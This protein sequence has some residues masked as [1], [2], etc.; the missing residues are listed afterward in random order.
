MHDVSIIGRDSTSFSISSNTCDVI[1]PGDSC[2]I[3]VAFVPIS[4]GEK[5]AKLQIY[6]N[7]PIDSIQTIN[8]SGVGLG[9]NLFS[10]GNLDF[11]V[12]ELGDSISSNYIIKN[13]GNTILDIQSVTIEGN[14]V[15]DFYFMGLPDV[16]F[17]IDPEDSVIIELVFRP[18]SLGQKTA[19]LVVSSND[20]HLDLEILGVCIEPVFAVEGS[21]VTENNTLVDQGRIFLYNLGANATSYSKPIAGKDTFRIVSSVI[22]TYTLRYDPDHEIYPGYLNTYL[23]DTPFYEEA[24]QFTLDNDTSYILIRLAPVPPPPEGDGEISGNLVDEQ[25]GGGGRI[26]YGRYAGDG[27]PV[28]NAMVLLL[29]TEEEIIDYNY[30]DASGYFE[31]QNIPSGSYKF[32]AD[33]RFYPMDPT[34]DNLVLDDNNKSLEIVATVDN[35]MISARLAETTGLLTFEQGG[36]TAYPIPVYNQLSV[37]LPESFKDTHLKIRLI[38]TIG[39]EC[40]F[41]NSEIY[42]ESRIL[43]LDGVV[44]HLLDGVYIMV[45]ETEEAGY[46]AKII[47]R[48][49]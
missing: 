28:E 23:G 18:S 15:S 11:G 9:P 2:E 42:Q 43:E 37:R 19:Q 46:Y 25:G 16:P 47:K 4:N 8:L 39:Q 27:T 48:S 45:I 14:D 30:T 3:E 12:V 5:I 17:S 20:E 44:N 29:N 22:G 38:N 1:T 35:D 31:F 26:E 33:Y 49:R 32:Y 34:N 6:C 13:V 21:A 36:F 7:D 41:N 24:T 40:V 10:Y